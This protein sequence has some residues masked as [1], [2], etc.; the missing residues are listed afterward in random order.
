MKQIL[1]VKYWLPVLM[2]TLLGAYNTHAQKSAKSN[3][4]TETAVLMTS[5]QCDM[6]KA[7][8]EGK[9]GEAKGVRMVSLDIRSKKLTVKYNPEKTTVDEIRKT[10]TALGYDADD[11][12]GDAEAHKNLPACCQKH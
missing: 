2:F 5:A 12:K 6:C 7:R 3:P 9:L 8:I 11:T 10:V 4:V 1:E